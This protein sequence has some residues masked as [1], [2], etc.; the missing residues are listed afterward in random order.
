MVVAEVS[1]HD[2][3]LVGW[4]APSVLHVAADRPGLTPLPVPTVEPVSVRLKTGEVLVLAPRACWWSRRR[5]CTR[6]RW[7]CARPAA[8]PPG[9]GPGRD[10][11]SRSPRG[12]WPSF[13]RPEPGS[14]PG[15]G[16]A[17][18][19]EAPDAGDEHQRHDLLVPP[20]RHQV[21]GGAV[22]EREGLEPSASATTA[23]ATG[24]LTHLEEGL[25]QRAHRRPPGE[26]ARCAEA[27][28]T[29]PGRGDASER[30][31][32][33]ESE[34]CRS[35]SSSSGPSNDVFGR[36]TSARRAKGKA[37]SLPSLADV[38]KT[39][40]CPRTASRRAVR[41][42]LISGWEVLSNS[43]RLIPC[44]AADRSGSF[45]PP[46]AFGAPSKNIS[47]IRTWSWNHSR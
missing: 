20:G 32:A 28:R 11:S 8:R 6:T 37:P 9:T 5:A 35:K 38:L 42:R 3:Q 25:L 21:A 4:A 1:G 33:R 44:P 19:D 2:V 34:L 30:A 7:A 13:R 22:A 29:G 26:R 43:A 40:H 24:Y 46:F 31:L 47:S 14:L 23:N 16:G 27:P 41:P 10:S 17:L 36:Q 39:S 18:L 12:R 15:P 45:A